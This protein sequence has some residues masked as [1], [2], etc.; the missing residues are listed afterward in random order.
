MADL[1]GTQVALGATAVGSG[2]SGGLMIMKILP[3]VLGVI[4]TS[5]FIV[6]TVLSIIWRK[7]KIDCDANIKKEKDD[8]EIKI[9]KQTLAN[10]ENNH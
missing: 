6:A 7:R 9:L 8:L 2:V 10:G 1:E 4:A 3:D 5:V